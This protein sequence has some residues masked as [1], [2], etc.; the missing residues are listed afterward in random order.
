MG[1]WAAHRQPRAEIKH[2]D[3]HVGPVES[4]GGPIVMG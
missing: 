2:K 4:S 3:G 1:A